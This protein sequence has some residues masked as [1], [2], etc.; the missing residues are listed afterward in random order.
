MSALHV[1]GVYLCL[2]WVF[3]SMISGA[4]MAVAI[5]YNGSG[6]PSLPPDFWQVAPYIACGVLILSAALLPV[7]L[8]IG[9]RP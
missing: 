1:F 4:I 6:K 2:V 8:F 7:F 3:G 5:M 9:P